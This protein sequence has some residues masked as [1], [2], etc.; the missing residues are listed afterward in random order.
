MQR[1]AITVGDPCGIG[2]EVSLKAALN[3]DVQKQCCLVLIGGARLLEQQATE[4]RLPWSDDWVVEEVLAST[5]QPLQILSIDD[6]DFSH[7]QRGQDGPEGGHASMSYLKKVV[8]LL[9]NQHVDA[10]ATAPI[11]KAAWR[12][13]GYDDPGHTEFFARSFGVSRYLMSFF[14]EEF[15]LAVLTR[16]VPL[17][18]VASQINREDLLSMLHLIQDQVKPYS[19]NGQVKIGV[20]GLNPHAGEAG[21][22]GD[23]ELT[24]IIPALEQARQEGLDV[25]GPFPADSFFIPQKLKRYDFVLAMYHDQG[26]IPFKMLAFETGINVTLGLPY[27]RT[28]VD[29]GT[30][31]DIV[32]QNK[33]HEGSM[34]AA[35]EW[36]IRFQC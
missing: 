23:E 5:D 25:E 2:P 3:A 20:C 16:H 13:A 29:H 14:S 8:E 21:K 31:Y 35:I 36:A 34:I 6:H 17:K 9:Q 15:K 22:I 10:V 12:M 11:S 1:I 18:D 30:A 24:T 7:Y 33:A 19:Q 26:L 28:S 27:M 32:A 4:L